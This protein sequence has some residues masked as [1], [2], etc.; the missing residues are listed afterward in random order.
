MRFIATVLLLLTFTSSVVAQDPPPPA[1]EY[2]PKIW[3]EFTSTEGR[4][5]VLL[6]GTPTQSD[7]T[8]QTRIGPVKVRDFEVRSDIS[9]YYL[10]YSEFPNVGPLTP[11]EQKEMLASSRDRAL[12]QGGTLISEVDV[13]VAGNPSKELIVARDGLIL[14]ARILYANDKLY[15]LILGVQTNTAFMNGKP[16]AKAADR[17][18]LYEEISAKYFNSFK[19]TK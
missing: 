19:L 18:A 16:S 3:K 6:P 14:R 15:N 13:S 8:L 4:F 2:N 10:S 1:K 12:S 5:S 17:T 9:V 11:E 7:R